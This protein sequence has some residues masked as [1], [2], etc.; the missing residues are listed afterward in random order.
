MN[1]EEIYYH[2]F[3]LKQ[4]QFEDDISFITAEK[5][6]KDVI[7]VLTRKTKGT[8]FQPQKNWWIEVTDLK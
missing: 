4:F 2:G 3:T 6:Y 8:S 7:K 5:D 1:K